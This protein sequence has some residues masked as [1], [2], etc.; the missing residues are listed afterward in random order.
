MG[1][2][3]RIKII[4]YICIVIAL[5]ILLTFLIMKE[6]YRPD[7]MT[8]TI[9]LVSFILL[10]YTIIFF[11]Y[12]RY[13]NIIFNISFVFSITLYSY[14][15]IAIYSDNKNILSFFEEHLFSTGIDGYIGI[16][17]ISTIL[18]LILSTIRNKYIS[19]YSQIIIQIIT[20]FLIMLFLYVTFWDDM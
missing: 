6:I 12:R 17:M 16:G 18:L 9:R 1:K 15:R 2:N 7:D 4:I 8:D 3:M 5:N 11:G 14:V 10:L 13:A 20:V 19:R